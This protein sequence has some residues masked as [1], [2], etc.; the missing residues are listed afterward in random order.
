M[1]ENNS[2]VAIRESHDRADNAADEVQ[3]D[4]VNRRNPSIVTSRLRALPKKKYLVMAGVFAVLLVALIEIPQL[5]QKW[6]WMGQLDYAG[7]FWTLLSVQWGM[8]CLAFIGVFLFLWL[9]IRQAAGTASRWQGYDTAKEAG[10]GEK[11][12]GIEIEGLIFSGRV[13]MRSLPLTWRPSLRSLLSVFVRNGTRISAFITVF[14][15][16]CQTRS[17]ESTWGFISLVFRFTSSCKTASYFDAAG[18][19]SRRFPLCLFRVPAAQGP[20]A[21]LR[22]AESYSTSFPALFH[23]GR[24]PWMGLLPGSVQPL[25]LAP[26]AWSMALDIRRPT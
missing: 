17:S 16:G 26:R 6:L 14:L 8:G 19:R 10:S 21:N 15:A 13:V 9:N 1:S 12:R 25:V 3:K 23:L 11:T 18:D 4:G 24:C 2:P 5:L 7:I 22:L 20:P